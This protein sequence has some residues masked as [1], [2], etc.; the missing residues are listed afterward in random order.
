VVIIIIFLFAVVFLFV[1]FFVR[2]LAKED[3][4]SYGAIR[5]V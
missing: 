2:L 3:I 4:G 5:R 1:V